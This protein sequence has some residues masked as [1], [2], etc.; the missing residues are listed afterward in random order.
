VSVTQVIEADLTY[1]DGAFAPGVRVAVGE[2]G[3][4]VDVGV[5]AAVTRRLEGGALVPGMINAHSHAFQRG[6][7]GLGEHFPDGAGSFW[8]WRE[9]MYALVEQMDPD[10]AYH[11]SRQAFAEMRRA[12]M[13]TVG[14]FHYLR[15][16]ASG[17]GFGLDDAVL[18][19]AKDVGIR[20]VLLAAHYRRGGFDGDLAGGQRRFDTV[21]LETYWDQMDRLAKRLDPATQT[22]GAV[23]HSIRAVAPDEIVALYEES[24]RRTLVF[25]M[26]VEEQ[27]REIAEC[28]EH[29]H[30][31]PMTLLNERLRITPRFTAVHCTHTAAE[32]MRV[33]LEAGGNVCICP[34]TE[35]NLGDGIADLPGMLRRYGRV[36]L[37][38]DSN[39]RIS[40]L[41]EMR[42][43]EYVQRLRHQRRGVC[44][45]DDGDVASTL[46]AAATITGAHALGVRAGAIEVGRWADFALV[47]L[48][49]DD[50]AGWTPE[51]LLPALV[52][53][54]GDGVI[55]GSCVGGRWD[56]ARD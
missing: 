12:G 3:R 13:T 6:L 41:E 4:I 24:Q 48:D 47:D 33:F 8:S 55:A 50:L 29:E 5:D 53:G 17:T 28:I 16:D 15:H 9:A 32:D 20:L 35:A 54:A 18:R 31:P 22:L 23:A 49:H 26:H 21:S 46:F 27:P 45:N 1:V 36:C 44:V 14:E 34:L 10:R 39:A 2:Q 38:S 43:L 37:G 30:H 19:A 42:W 25:H 7:R 51:T 56:P 11:L 40:M 52:L